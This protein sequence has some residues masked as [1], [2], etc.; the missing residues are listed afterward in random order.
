MYRAICK[1]GLI[2]VDLEGASYSEQLG[3]VTT[4]ALRHLSFLFRASFGYALAIK[5][6]RHLQPN[7]SFDAKHLGMH[8]RLA[9]VQGYVNWPWSFIVAGSF[10][11]ASELNVQEKGLLGGGPQ[12]NA[13]RMPS[14]VERYSLALPGPTTRPIGCIPRPLREAQGR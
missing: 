10:H 13:R 14:I 12:Q 1:P 3:S 7:I 5:T 8:Q 6:R 11:D 4:A 9:R 2:R